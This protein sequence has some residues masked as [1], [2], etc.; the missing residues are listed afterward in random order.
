MSASRKPVRKI[1]R[2]RPGGRRTSSRWRQYAAV[3]VSD[4]VADLVEVAHESERREGH[5]TE[6]EEDEETSPD[7]AERLGRV[8]GAVAGERHGRRYGRRH[9]R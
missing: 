6:Q 1:A 3:E 9:G 5:G 7:A 2:L 8:G 4:E